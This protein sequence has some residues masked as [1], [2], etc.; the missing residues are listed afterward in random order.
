MKTDTGVVLG[1]DR[2][3]VQQFGGI[4]Y[5]APPVG[6]LRW[7]P[8]Q[9]ASAWTE[10]RDAF[11]LGFP[12]PQSASLF[13]ASSTTEDCLF[14]NVWKPAGAKDA[15]VLVWFHGGAFV[16]GS[17]GEPYYD[18][19]FLAENRGVIVVGVNYRLGALG[20]LTLPELA[21]EDPAHPTSGNYGILDQR[22]ALQWVQ[23]N[24]RAFGGDPGRVTI[25]GES[26]GGIS[27]CLHYVSP[28]TAGL[29][30][31]ALSESGLCTDNTLVPT[32]AESES[33][34]AELA[35]RLGCSGVACMRGKTV[36]QIATAMVGTPVANQL[37]GGPFYYS[38]RDILMVP[39]I[40][41]RV[42]RAALREAFPAGG[43]EPRPLLLGSNKDEGTIFHLEVI[44]K[45]VTT[46]QEFRDALARRYGTAAVDPIIA[47][48]P[49]ASF[50]SFDR[51]LA[52][53][54]GDEMFVCP[55]R[56]AARGAAAAGAPVY[57]YSFERAPEQ[58]LFA[59]L[60]VFHSAE[61]PFV[62]GT[63]DAYLF[64]K[65][66]PA[67]QPVAEKMQAYWTAFA[68]TGSPGVDWPRY[69]AAADT[70]LVL[71]VVTG[72][73]SGHKATLCDF[74]DTTPSIR[75]PGF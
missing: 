12:C 26:A 42:I 32:R 5:A 72:P 6:S 75:P 30:H 51:T 38:A 17:G 49:V 43:F 50:P 15:P 62:F 28:D 66:G 59:G 39:N 20:F 73:R 67:S 18:G 11:E 64:A 46:E 23:R 2:G 47:K 48:Y 53:I 27:T 14:L 56:R 54:A 44:A 24:I 52:E 65:V 8:P 40:D 7:K 57:A 60:G 36:E 1:V 69:S 22:A 16:F 41:G 63:G 37:P 71:D 13:G 45:S 25:F 58:A 33:N 9:P 70:L 29:F 3:A 35:R 19:S 55:T 61:I 21:S 10:P 74:W 31:A 68:E 4:P 34:G